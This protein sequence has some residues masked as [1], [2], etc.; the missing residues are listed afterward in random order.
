MN[1]SGISN[2]SDCPVELP[3]VLKGIQ[4]AVTRKTLNGE[5]GP[6]LIEEAL[7]MEEAIKSYT[8]FGAYSSF[9]EKIKGSIEKDKVAD[10]VI[11]DKSLF[12]V[13]E[14]QIKDIQILET[15]VDGKCVYKHKSAK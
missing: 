2:G 3:N 7:S 4:C 9:E 10:F 12:K 1:N 6:Y 5:K 15:Y 11:M 14:S 13:P 8:I